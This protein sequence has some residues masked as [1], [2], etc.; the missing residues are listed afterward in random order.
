MDSICPDGWHL[1]N[2][3]EWK[4]LLLTVDSLFNSMDSSTAGKKLKSQTGWD[5]NGNGDD[6]FGFS[7]MHT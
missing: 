3:A 7:D 6:T 2:D 5:N 1:P 4:E